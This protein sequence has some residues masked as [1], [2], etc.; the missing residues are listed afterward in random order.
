MQQITPLEWFR[1][2]HFPQVSQVSCFWKKHSD[3]I[4]KVN[5]VCNNNKKEL[6]SKTKTMS[7]RDDP[8]VIDFNKQ[9]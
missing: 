7:A 5:A 9:A 2:K 6:F 8:V 3:L 1:I 4:V